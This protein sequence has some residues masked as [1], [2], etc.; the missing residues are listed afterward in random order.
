[1]WKN[2]WFLQQPSGP[3]RK[4][5]WLSESLENESVWLIKVEKTAYSISSLGLNLEGDKFSSE[6]AEFELMVENPSGMLRKHWR[7]K[8]GAWDRS[9]RYAN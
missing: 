1:M 4:G 7:Y 2:T 9:P 8:V 3:G 6:Y 5:I